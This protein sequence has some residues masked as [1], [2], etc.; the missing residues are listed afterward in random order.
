MQEDTSFPMEPATRRAAEVTPAEIREGL[1]RILGSREFQRARRNRDFLRYVVSEA[2]AGRADRIKAYSIA[3]SALDRDESF[4]AQADPVVRLEA[5]QLRRRI[6]RYYLTDGVEDPVRIDMPKGGY[7]PVFSRRPAAA[8][9]A[10]PAPPARSRVTAWMSG[11]VPGAVLAAAIS[12]VVLSA[13][14]VAGPP[15]SFLPAPHES[16]P[17]LAI[18]PFA[19]V[20]GNGEPLP[21]E[22]LAEGLAAGL[23]EEVARMLTH[24]DGVAVTSAGGS[25]RPP[26]PD[27]VLSGSV[28]AVD[29]T[30]RITARLADART[31]LLLWSRIYDHRTGGLGEALEIQGAA[32]A[33]IAAHLASPY[34]VL[35]QL[36]RGGGTGA[37]SGRQAAYECL[38]QTFR[39]RE[40]PTAQA[41]AAARRCT[42]R[43]LRSD[44]GN[45]VP[46][47]LSALLLL[48]AGRFQ[49][50]PRPAPTE[51]LAAAAQAAE[52][53]LE[54]ESSS[55]L[56]LQ[57]ASAVQFASGRTGQAV[58][59]LER[60]LELAPQ[61]PELLAQLGTYLSFL[62]RW[63]EGGRLVEA[64]LTFGDSGPGWYHFV[65]ACRDYRRQAYEA[66]RG[67]AV[68]AADSGLPAAR[69]LLA[70][71]RTR[72]GEALPPEPRAGEGGGTAPGM[73]LRDL[74]GLPLPAPLVEEILAGLVP[75]TAGG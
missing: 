43:A 17:R 12:I 32:A 25:G 66:A 29:G 4:D 73:D 41:Y 8:S 11:A 51:V 24:Y 28:R 18:E 35:A 34:G 2:L 56:A 40:A 13:A 69:P 16:A 67:H 5:G 37:G 50:E 75:H 14:F 45:A 23:D 63:E 47:A 33:G 10:S 44:P 52:Q 21:A 1:E 53:A 57:A 27:L 38:L 64:A 61:D 6:E 31:S 7:V 9:A 30:V 49:E 19:A 3:V 15:P 36:A 48:E 20:G 71:I 46:W 65:L 60:A 70:A 58:A 55:I 54:L 42:D 59:V 62:G 22:G 74:H 72:L 68:S 26:A 39:H